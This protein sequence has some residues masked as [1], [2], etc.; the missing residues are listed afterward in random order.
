MDSAAKRVVTHPINEAFAEQKAS[1]WGLPVQVTSMC[2]T[3]SIYIFDPS[4]L[5][6][7]KDGTDEGWENFFGSVRGA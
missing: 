6:G 2:P 5:F 3:N 1:L 4:R 7:G